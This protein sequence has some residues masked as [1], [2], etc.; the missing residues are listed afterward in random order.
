MSKEL[1]LNS[2]NT[3]PHGL[4]ASA[5]PTNTR[6]PLDPLNLPSLPEWLTSRL[7]MVSRERGYHRPATIPESKQLN[8]SERT[9]VQAQLGMLREL[10]SNTSLTSPET[11]N[12]VLGAV[13]RMLLALP[14]KASG[15]ATGEAKADAYMI[16]LEDMPAW[17][18]TA[19]IRGWYRGEHGADH[20]YTFAPAPADLRKFAMAERWK[21]AG[22]VKALEELLEAVPE[23][24]FSDE[25]RREMLGKLRSIGLC[26]P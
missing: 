26:S 23:I 14:S 19:A 9:A 25:H 24:E 8:L 13:T 15:E 11:A 20:N 5:G 18:V 3:R 7:G 12:E 21:V 10:F 2:S 17:A 16:A 1:T 4:T 6:Q 22:R